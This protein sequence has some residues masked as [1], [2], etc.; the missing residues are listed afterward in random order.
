[1]EVEG[2]RNEFAW[3]SV[4]GF[5]CVRIEIGT[6]CARLADTNCSFSQRAKLGISV[7][8]HG[9]VRSEGRLMWECGGGE[10]VSVYIVCM[11]VLV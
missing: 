2:R 5:V 7:S 11:S 1:M 6:V 9:T 8:L 4:L 3:R 10:S